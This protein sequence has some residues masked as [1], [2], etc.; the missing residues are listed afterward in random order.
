MRPGLVEVREA[1]L[2]EHTLQVLFAEHDDVVQAFPTHAP[3]K[4]LAERV[5]ARGFH[6]GAEDP[7]AGCLGCSFEVGREL[8]VV[9][10][11]SGA[12]SPWSASG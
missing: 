12:G 11:A 5:H 7:D 6:R 10:A 8:V 3:Q 4:P 1:I 2:T 9:V